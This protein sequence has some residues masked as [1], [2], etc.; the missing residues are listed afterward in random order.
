MQIVT[1]MGQMLE[2][3]KVMLS[4]KN[5][6]TIEI[7]ANN[8]KID[9]NAKNKDLIKDMIASVRDSGKNISITETAK[10]SPEMLKTAERTRKML[11]DVAEELKTAGITITLSYKGDVVATM[12]AQA[13]ARVSRLVTGTKA[14][15]INS[16]PKLIELGI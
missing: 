1:M 16:L 7:R 12:G 14:I 11:I 5:K 4:S 13:S 15:E 9:V 6:E 2:S 3:G 8:K 10:E